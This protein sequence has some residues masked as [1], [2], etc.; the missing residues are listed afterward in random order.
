MATLVEN[1]QNRILAKDPG[2]A[3]AYASFKTK[4]QA[5]VS[6]IIQN[7]KDCFIWSMYKTRMKAQSDRE[8]KAKWREV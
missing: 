8:V 1:W 7:G 3:Q 6:T 5:Q 4:R 2:V